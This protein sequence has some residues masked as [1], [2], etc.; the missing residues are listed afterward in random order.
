MLDD[1]EFGTPDPIKQ[2]RPLTAENIAAMCE[3]KQRFDSAHIAHK[4]AKRRRKAGVVREVYRCRAC[5][6]FHIGKP[7][8]RRPIIH[9]TTHGVTKWGKQS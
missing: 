6:G 8:E 9:S 2:G 1:S 3:G 7:L 5:G 4:A